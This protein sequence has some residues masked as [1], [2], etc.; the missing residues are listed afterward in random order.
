[1]LDDSFFDEVDDSE[2]L[3]VEES[4][5]EDP[6]PSFVALEAAFSDDLD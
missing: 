5:L 1:L 3:D 4:L 2:G 6:A